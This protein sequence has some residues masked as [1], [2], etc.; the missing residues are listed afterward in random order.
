VVEELGQSYGP[1]VRLI[2]TDGV[3]AQ[4][5]EGWSVIRASNT[6]EELVSR[7]EGNSPEARDRIGKDLMDRLR[8]VL[9]RHGLEL[10]EA[11]H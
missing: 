9:G 1:G 5:P 7:W 11:D 4:F 10:R 6:G 3:R 8:S 2:R